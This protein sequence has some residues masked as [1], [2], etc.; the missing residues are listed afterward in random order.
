MDLNGFHRISMDFT[1]EVHSRISSITSIVRSSG[2]SEISRDFTH[3]NI[4]GKYFSISRDFKE[5]QE[6]SRDFKIF[7]G[8]TGFH[9]EGVEQCSQ[10]LI[11]DYHFHAWIYASISTFVLV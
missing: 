9:Y 5:F 10:S 2:I 8:I 1:Q 4:L 3:R 6:I 7:Q 11:S